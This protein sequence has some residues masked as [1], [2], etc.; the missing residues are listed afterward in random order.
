MMYLLYILPFLYL[1]TI[2]AEGEEKEE[3]KGMSAGEFVSLGVFNSSVYSQANHG[4]DVS[5]SVSRDTADC[6]VKD[7]SFMIAR[8][9]HKLHNLFCIL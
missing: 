2:N 6:L 1:T 9:Y 4:L 3:A 8:G 5:T 7:Y